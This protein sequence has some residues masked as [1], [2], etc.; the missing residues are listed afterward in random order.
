M[1]IEGDETV[2]VFISA[3][4]RAGLTNVIFRL[5]QLETLYRRLGHIECEKAIQDA[6]DLLGML[7]GS[8][9][10]PGVVGLIIDGGR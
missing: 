8:R 7:E 6:C 4:G 10:P 2:S 5:E 9:R 1:K 3:A